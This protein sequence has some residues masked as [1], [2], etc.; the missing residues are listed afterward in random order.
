MIA[1][2]RRGQGRGRWS[3]GRALRSRS[4]CR[5]D[6][7]R[8]RRR[9]AGGGRSFTKDLPQRPAAAGTQTLGFVP[10]GIVPEFRVIAQIARLLVTSSCLQ[11]AQHRVAFCR[12]GHTGAWTRSRSCSST[13]RSTGASTSP[14]SMS[15]SSASSS[16]RTS[17]EASLDRIEASGIELHDDCARRSS[18]AATPRV[19]YTNGELAGATADALQLFLNQIGRYPLLTAAAGGRARASASSA[20][21][22]RRRT[23]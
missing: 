8:P 9:R 12:S 15:S 17:I 7:E 22:P 16:T 14:S 21:T 3:H 2:S 11:I 13:A 1:P 4:G 18:Q 19:A 20:A 10:A 23:G 6:T 5:Y